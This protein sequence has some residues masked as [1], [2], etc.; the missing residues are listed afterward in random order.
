M[1][2]PNTP[3]LGGLRRLL[4]LRMADWVLIAVALWVV[5]AL[6]APQQVPVSV[7]KMSLVALAAVMGYWIDR[8]VFPYARPDLFFELTHGLDDDVPA[9][10]A[11]TDL[12]GALSFSEAQTVV[13]LQGASNADLVALARTAMLRRALI[14]AATMLAVSLGA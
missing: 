11:F 4:R 5:V 13:D 2:Q 3:P 9:E 12:G 7:Y 14:V 10:T 8:S 1:T 6:L